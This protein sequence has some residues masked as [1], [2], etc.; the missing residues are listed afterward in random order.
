VKHEEFAERAE[1]RLEAVADRLEGEGRREGTV[2]PTT[3]ARAQE[4]KV[5]ALVVREEARAVSRDEEKP[6]VGPTGA[7]PPLEARARATGD[8]SLA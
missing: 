5:A 1:R 2:A 4:R 6:L 7:N 8:P 3:I